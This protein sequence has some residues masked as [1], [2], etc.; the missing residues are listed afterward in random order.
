MLFQVIHPWQGK[1]GRKDIA[2]LTTNSF[3]VALG[4][5]ANLGFEDIGFDLVVLILAAASIFLLWRNGRQPLLIYYTI[6]YGVGLILTAV[7]RLLI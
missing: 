7:Y 1:V 4:I 3:F 5:F 2:L 6:A